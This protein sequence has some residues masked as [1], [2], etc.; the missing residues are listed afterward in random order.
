MRNHPIE[1]IEPKEAANE[2]ENS[3]V[4]IL[5]TPQ[6]STA[7]AVDVSIECFV[8]LL[9]GENPVHS[10]LEATCLV[11]ANVVNDNDM[12]PLLVCIAL[13]RIMIGVPI[14]GFSVSLI[15]LGAK[16]VGRTSFCRP[17]CEVSKESKK[18]RVF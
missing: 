10:L 12:V 13:A 2:K 7:S 11:C 4:G 14:R 6:I 16:K 17:L 15:F 18:V 8:A 1:E 3:F 9:V 5:E